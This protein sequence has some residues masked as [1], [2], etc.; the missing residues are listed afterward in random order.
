MNKIENSLNSFS[1]NL[2]VIACFCMPFSLPLSRALL[3]ISSVTAIVYTLISRKKIIIPPVL[4]LALLFCLWA[5]LTV[6]TSPVEVQI[7]PKL[8]K[9]IWWLT[10]PVIPILLNSS[11]RVIICLTAYCFGSL[12]TSFK[13]FFKITNGMILIMNSDKN[14]TQILNS[15]FS[16]GSMTDAQRLMVSIIII[17]VMVGY[18]K[19][20][21]DSILWV[22]VLALNVFAVI[23]HFKRCAW[24]STLVCSIPGLFRRFGFKTILLLLTFSI[25]MGFFNPVKE[26]VIKLSDELSTKKGG[27]LTMWVKIAPV[28]IK[29]Y[30]IKGIGF[31]C[32]TP[33]IMRSI[34]PEV[35]PNRNHLHSNPVEI[36]A[37][38]GIV[39]FLLYIIWMGKTLIDAVK[40][41]LKARKSSWYSE[42]INALSSLLAFCGLMIAGM[43]EYNFADGEIIIIYVLLMGIISGGNIRLQKTSLD[44]AKYSFLSVIK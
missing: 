7:L 41:Y 2:F 33:E 21:R 1:Y 8:R 40:Y 3:A 42:E 34:Y 35:E 28:I 4:W 5:S 19:S 16:Y 44:A 25:I 37:S 17:C 20:L 43:V 29:K 39:G 15:I 9:L 26:R 30:P 13:T 31:R 32:I 23:L 22:I 10:I 12:V 27:R 11:Q 24:I 38:T 6:I 14:T 18:T 36:I